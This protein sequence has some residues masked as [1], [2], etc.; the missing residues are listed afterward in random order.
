MEDRFDAANQAVLDLEEFGELP[1]P[2]DL[3]VVEERKRE[4]DAP[5]AIDGDESPVAD[6]RDDAAQ[7]LLELLLAV[8]L[9]HGDAILEAITVIGERVIA[10]PVVAGE[11]GEVMVGGLDQLL[12]RGALCR[13]NR[14]A[15]D[16]MRLLHRFDAIA[17]AAAG[18]RCRGPGSARAAS[19]RRCG[20]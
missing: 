1:G 20:S 11:T 18:W 8:P 15:V 19:G 9:R 12:A 14:L 13:R 6:A 10:L 2:V 16:R 7:R 4:D 17:D 5:L 3:L